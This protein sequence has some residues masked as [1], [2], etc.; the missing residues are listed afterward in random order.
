MLVS[1]RDGGKS[2]WPQEVA[3]HNSGKGALCR[4]KTGLNL[5]LLPVVAIK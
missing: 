1:S 4:E 2:L 3:G 5:D